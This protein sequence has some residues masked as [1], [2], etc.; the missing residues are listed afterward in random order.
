MQN[1]NLKQEETIDFLR[2][3]VR[4]GS[5]YHLTASVISASNY[6]TING[7]KF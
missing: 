6:G 5:G 4:S 1:K 2:E 7:G 3:F